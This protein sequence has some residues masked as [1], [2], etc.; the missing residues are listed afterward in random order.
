MVTFVEKLDVPRTDKLAAVV[1]D[2][3]EKLNIPSIFTL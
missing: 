1:G 2:T 3:S